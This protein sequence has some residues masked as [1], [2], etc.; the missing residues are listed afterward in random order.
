MVNAS[1]KSNLIKALN[2]AKDIV[3][4]GLDNVETYKNILD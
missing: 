4:L 2:Y 3:I 1:G